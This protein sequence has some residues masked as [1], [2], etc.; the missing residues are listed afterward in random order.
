MLNICETQLE[1]CYRGRVALSVAAMGA[2]I[3]FLVMLLPW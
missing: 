1:A 3:A 2:S